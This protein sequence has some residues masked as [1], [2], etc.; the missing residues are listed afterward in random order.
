MVPGITDPGNV[1]GPTLDPGRVMV[2]RDKEVVRLGPS[3]DFEIGGETEPGERD[4]EEPMIGGCELGS[5][6]LGKIVTVVIDTE[7]RL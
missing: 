7:G 1:D 5:C 6:E 3:D 2:V 4:V